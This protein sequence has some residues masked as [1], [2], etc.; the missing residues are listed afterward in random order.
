MVPQAGSS[1]ATGSLQST[2]NGQDPAGGIRGLLASLFPAASSA[3]A[4]RT[5]SWRVLAAAAQIAAV[6]LGTVVLL[7]RVPGIPPWDTVYAEDYFLFL[8]GALQH[9]W[10]LFVAFDGYVQIVPRLIAQLVTYLPLADAARG[11]A[12]IGALVAALC[13]LF[14]FH[15]SA[16]HIRSVTLRVLLAS[17]VILLS[18]APMEI[19]DSG[20]NTL[21]YLG[22]AM[23]W[24]VLWRPRTPAG[25]AVAAAVSFLVTASTIIVILYAPMLAMRL[26]VLR[27]PREHAVTAGWLAGCLLQARFVVGATVSGQSRLVGGGGP[28]FGRD[29]RWGNSLTFYLHDVV[30]RWAGW[31]L[32]WRLQSFTTINR[33][34][35]IAGVALAAVLGLIIATQ[36]GARP[37]IVVA[38]TTGFAFT[39]FAVYLD[40]WDVVFPVTFKNEVAARY[41][42]LPIMAIEASLIVGADYALRKRHENRV[43]HESRVR[44]AAGRRDAAAALRRALAVTALIA[45]LAGN[46]VADFRY[47]GIRSGPAAHQWA[48]V[49]AQ[50]RHDCQVSPNG[51]I[52]PAVGKAAR[53]AIPCGNIR[54]LLRRREPDSGG[55][56]SR[57]GGTDREQRQQSLDK[58]SDQD[59]VQQGPDAE[60]AAEQPA[61][62]DDADLERGSHHPDRPPGAPV[63]AGHQAVARAWTELG[64]DVHGG[65]DRVARDARRHQRGPGG[66]RVRLMQEGQSQVGRQADHERVRDRAKPRHLAQRHPR[67]QHHQADR[68]RDGPDA[69]PEVA[70]DALVQHVPGSVAQASADQAGER[71]AVQQKAR[72]QLRQAPREP[73]GP[74]LFKRP[75]LAGRRARLAGRRRGPAGTGS[76]VDHGASTPRIGTSPK[77]QF[78]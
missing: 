54:F 58:G 52:S 39:M 17:G 62:H 68:D 1:A 64:A 15:A 19:A 24:A 13:G 71:E 60:H 41:T 78:R 28:A 26:F 43:R 7:L 49:A 36:P 70:G 14:I 29:N 10:H 33:A 30:L 42:A 67:E 18:S 9:P 4:P 76:E 53:P 20:V 69:D 56:S 75:G 57:R 73:A 63:Q 27:R 31:H 38:M 51:V 11:L 23:F 6:A 66:Q 37:F 55:P 72:V 12:A 22:L 74:Q 48:P 45:F 34:T 3:A 50:W 21:W 46:W 65:R 2:P 16:G 8:P 77:G 40:P 32:S 44:H 25:I 59:R 61:E 5:W 35:L 47:Y